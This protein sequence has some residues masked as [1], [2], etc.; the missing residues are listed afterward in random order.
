[1]SQRPTWFTLVTCT[2]AEARE[3]ATHR[4]QPRLSESGWWMLSVKE[5]STCLPF[6]VVDMSSLQAGDLRSLDGPAGLHPELSKT[7]SWS[8]SLILKPGE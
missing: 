1:M 8:L 4:N 5:Q 7:L 6:P 2:E 3:A